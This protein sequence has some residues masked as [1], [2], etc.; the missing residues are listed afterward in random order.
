ML[1]LLSPAKKLDFTPNAPFADHSQP[2]FIKD[3]SLIIKQAKL[4]SRQEIGQ[5]MHISD[6]LADLN[7]QRFHNFKTPFDLNNAKQAAYAF[8][9]DT[10]TGLDALNLNQDDILWSQNHVG[11]LSGLYGLLRPLDLIQPYRLEMGCKFNNSQGENLYDFWGDKLT[12]HI[13]KIIKNHKYK[14]VIACASSEYFKSIKV[15][16]L[17][18][19]LIYPIFKEIK[20]GQAKNI[21]I[22]AKRAR[23]T[24]TKFIIENRIENPEDLKDF[25]KDGYQFRSDLSEG[26]QWLFTRGDDI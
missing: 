8:N 20:A 2:D 16:S 1:S 10:Y 23:G 24:M 19:D 9:G 17:D 12:L 7:Y 3:S 4:L 5:L 21:G 6:K 25:T 13:N 11:I 26:N 18:S 14:T 15:K 22:F